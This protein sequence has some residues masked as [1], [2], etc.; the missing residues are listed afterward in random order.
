MF[1]RK[2]STSFVKGF[3]FG[4]A[5]FALAL[6]GGEAGAQ[7]LADSR[8][9]RPGPGEY[10]HLWLTFDGAGEPMRAFVGLRDGKS[11]TAWLLD[12]LVPGGAKKAGAYRLLLD[13]HDLA[14]LGDRLHGTIVVRQ[15][16]I[17]A[18]MKRV[19]EVT[20]KIDAKRSGGEFKGTWSSTKDGEKATAQ[21]AVTGTL[22]EES[23]L[24][25]DQALAPGADWP[26]YHGPFGTNQAASVKSAVVD[27]LAD[28][29]PIW[30]SEE[31]TRSG[32]G[33]G[34]DGRYPVRAAF[35]TVCG[36]TGTPIIADGRVYLFHYAPAGDPDPALLEKALADFEKQNQRKPTA[37]EHAGLIDFCRPL[38]DTIVV[39]LD[40]RTGAVVWR[41]TF[42]RFSGNF[43][44]HKWR[45]LNPTACIVGPVL[46][47]ADLSNN[48]VALKAA[49]GDVLWTIQSKPKVEGNRAVVGAVQAGKLAILPSSGSEPAR[50]V[51]PATGKVVWEQPGGPQA[52]VWGA[53]GAERV[54]FIGRNP[55][56]CH[57]AATGKLLW[58]MD[59]KLIGV[60]GSA[61]LIRDDILVGHVLPDAKK[62][63]GF[64]QGWKLADSGAAKLWQDEFLPYDENL[65]VSLGH[66]KAYL[67]GQNE[68]RCLDSKTGKRIGGQKFDEKTDSIGSNQWLGIVGDRLLLAPEG[69]HGSLVLQWLDAGPEL[70]I[71]GPRR[72]MPNNSTTAYGA[73][74]LAYPVV[75][76]R[77]F[78]RGMDGIYCYDLRTTKR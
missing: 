28:A 42:P 8:I 40:A 64:F 63:G 55:P 21:G 31:I 30:R 46:I 22:I 45:G 5:V 29:R 54:V 32:W 14:V 56:T 67:V 58:T 35:G 33:T 59:E 50:A 62:R 15:V 60:S 27:D 72:A 36:G 61:A 65:T 44:T 26:S 74:A 78:V 75:D 10:K 7:K 43:Q 13:S 9:D 51:D 76:G 20:L 66:G 16:T 37:A 24:R 38:A 39:C 70:K 1:P 19:A 53:S 77:L 52:L 11:T 71:L 6:H 23:T 48:W 17:W 69:Q 4:L 25:A 3:A 34:V 57:D 68:I 12:G 49:T 73:H 47:A 41:V 18:P 2:L